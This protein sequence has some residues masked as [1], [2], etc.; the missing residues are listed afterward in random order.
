MK[1]MLLIGSSEYG[2]VESPWSS[3]YGIVLACADVCSGSSLYGIVSSC[4]VDDICSGSSLYGIVSDCD[5]VCSG[6]S[7]C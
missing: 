5:D 6:G 3:L 4:D 7:C 2:N 1:N